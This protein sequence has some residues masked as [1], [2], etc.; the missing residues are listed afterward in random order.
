MTTIVVQAIFVCT[1]L[2][3]LGYLL[4]GEFVPRNGAL[5]LRLGLALPA[6]HFFVLMLMVVHILTGGE[7]FGR[8]G[9]VRAVTA[10]TGILLSVR[11]LR[12]NP[13]PRMATSEKMMLLGLVVLAGLVWG[14]PIARMLPIGHVGD[15]ILHMGWANQLLNGEPTPT[16]ALTGEIPNFYPWLFHAFVAFVACF[17]PVTRAFDAQGAV[18]LLQVGGAVLSLYA[19]GR[20]L[21]EQHVTGIGAALF[22]AMAGGFG[23]LTLSGPALVVDPRAEGGSAALQYMGDLL[24]R[25]SYNLAIHNLAP[26]FPRDVA[27]ALTHSYLLLLVIGIKRRDGR[28]LAGAGLT[29][30]LIGLTG[31]ETFLI[32]LITAALVCAFSNN[33]RS[34]PALLLIIAPSLMLWGLWA[35]PLALNFMRLGG[36]V[37]TASPLVALPPLGVVGSCGIASLVGLYGCLKRPEGL[38]S[39]ASGVIWALLAATGTMILVSG[40][41]VELA[42][43]GF[44]TLGRAHRYWPLAYL[45]LALWAAV[46][47]TSFLN[48]WSSKRAVALGGSFLVAAL[49]LPSPLLASIALPHELPPPQLLRISLE[50][51]VSS[52]LN[53]LA[54][55]TESQCTAAVP[56]MIA[57][58]AFAYTGFRLVW[59]P[60]STN[61]PT[62]AR[63][64]WAG[65]FERITPL[66]ERLRDNRILLGRSPSSERWRAVAQAYDVDRLLVPLSQASGLPSRA[67]RLG[68]HKYGSEAVIVRQSCER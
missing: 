31:A 37:N 20:E 54:S 58:S 25:R 15:Q 11:K 50:G 14:S 35:G 21:T 47:L 7:V 60:Y 22:G 5:W 16:A 40:F 55:S 18:L 26:T 52:P 36:F 63:I 38:S 6:L 51:D 13:S 61:D 45:G 59:F 48:R 57:R 53:L 39:D 29:L 34:G 32:G 28:L 9:L 4:A 46:G 49:A 62:R 44:A 8:P 30:G 33:V 68:E 67:M 17:M 64:R 10:A 12:G 19:L 56:R 23:F 41:I 1:G 24:Y 65:I 43:P 27:F 42:G 2:L 66:Q 3:A